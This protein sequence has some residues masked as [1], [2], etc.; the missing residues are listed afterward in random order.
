VGGHNTGGNGGGC[1][2][3][4]SEATACLPLKLLEGKEDKFLRYVIGSL[5]GRK[6]S[7][8]R[9]GWNDG[10]D[11]REGKQGLVAPDYSMMTGGGV[12]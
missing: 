5:Y 6:S 9:L 3:Y 2:A 11:S 10:T 4:V 12:N 7:S 1:I 8:D